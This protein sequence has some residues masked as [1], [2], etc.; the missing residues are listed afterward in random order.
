MIYYDYQPGRGG[1]RPLNILK[2]FKGHLQADGYAVYDELPLED[3]TVFYCMAH[4][5]RKIYDAQS[6]NEKL[7]SYA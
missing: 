6:N 1:E 5:R 3:I 4:A 7:A 2:D